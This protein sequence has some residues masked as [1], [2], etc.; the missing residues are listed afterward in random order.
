MTTTSITAA[1]RLAA[2]PDLDRRDDGVAVTQFVLHVVDRRRMDGQW[3]SVKVGNLRCTTWGRL[4]EHVHQSLHRGDRVVVVGQLREHTCA[5][6]DEPPVAELA[7]DDVGLSLRWTDA[8]PVD[9]T[10]TQ[11]NG[12]AAGSPRRAAP[13]GSAP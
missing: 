5:P 4:A 13:S 3:R 8:R 6:R 2:D 1:G 7:V 9:G 11:V 12:L 10:S